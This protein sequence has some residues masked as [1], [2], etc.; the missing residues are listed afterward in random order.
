VSFL[1]RLLGGGDDRPGDAPHDA[2][3]ATAEEQATAEQTHELEVLKEE[4]ARLDELQRRQLRYAGK[5]WTPP[6][7]GGQRRADDKADP[8]S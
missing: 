5:A 1:R 6:V 7:Q 2:P 3:P 8:E 4:A